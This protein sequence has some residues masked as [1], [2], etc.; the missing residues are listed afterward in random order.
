[1]VRVVLM[2]GWRTIAFNVIAGGFLFLEVNGLIGIVPK[3]YESMGALLVCMVNI[4][5]RTQTNT[6]VGEK[7]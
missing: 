3:G 5:L 7:T 6:A 1:M 4:Y 2:K